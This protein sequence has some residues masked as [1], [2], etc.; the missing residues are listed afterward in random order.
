MSH[1]DHL[2]YNIQF[3]KYRIRKKKLSLLY[4]LNRGVYI[5]FDITC[6]DEVGGMM[7]CK[8]IFFVC[9]IKIE[10]F[11]KVLIFLQKLTLYRSFEV[12]VC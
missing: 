1:Q 12:C 9:V 3:G 10:A 4:R 11:R 6:S 7:D 5:F 8:K 2:D